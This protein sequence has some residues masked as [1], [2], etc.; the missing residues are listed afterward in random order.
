MGIATGEM[1]D[2][3][4]LPGIGIDLLLQCSRISSERTKVER[5]EVVVKRFIYEFT[6]GGEWNN[7]GWMI[8]GQDILRGPIERSY[9]LN[10]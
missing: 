9:M 7:A 3:D 4:P 6:I 2:L 10:R 1:D 5:P 8:E